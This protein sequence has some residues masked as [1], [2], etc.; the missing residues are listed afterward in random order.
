MSHRDSILPGC[1]L[2]RMGYDNQ[3]FGLGGHFK[4]GGK[5]DGA[6]SFLNAKMEKQLND[7]IFKKP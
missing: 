7:A 3:T 4:G 1:Y 5:I 6:S 2:A